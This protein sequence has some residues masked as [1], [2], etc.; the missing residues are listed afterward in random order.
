MLGI[1][2]YAPSRTVVVPRG[3][4]F[5]QAVVLENFR[6]LYG[7]PGRPENPTRALVYCDDAGL[8]V[9]FE[10]SGNVEG[11]SV[12]LHVFGDG[13]RQYA[14]EREDGEETGGGWAAEFRVEWEE[15]GGKGEILRANFARVS[16]AETSSW[17]PVFSRF[18]NEREMGILSLGREAEPER[19]AVPNLLPAPPREPGAREGDEIALGRGLLRL[20]RVE[21]NEIVRGRFPFRSESYHTPEVHRFRERYGLDEVVAGASSELKALQALQAWVISRITFG[22]PHHGRMDAFAIL[23]DAAQ[24]HTFFCTHYGWVFHAAA[25][26]LGWVARKNTCIGHAGAE[27]WVN[28]HDKWVAFEPTRGHIF[29]KDGVPQSAVQVHNEWVRDGGVSMQRQKGPDGEVV[30]VTLE[31]NEQGMIRDAQERFLWFACPTRNDFFGRP[32]HLGAYRWVWY[33][34]EHNANVRELAVREGAK[35]TD[36]R[37]GSRECV[38][39]ATADPRDIEWSANRVEAHLHQVAGGLRVRLYHCMPNLSHFEADSG[40]GWAKADYEFDWPLKPGANTLRVRAVNLFGRAGKE[41]V[42]E[43]EF[44]AKAH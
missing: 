15:L 8:C 27:V 7:E 20:T 32:E 23:D 1:D 6:L 38:M 42:L 9:R 22:E 16:G 14:V 10:C 34:D 24:G 13:H 36:F 28:E 11:D 37:S 3:E 43:G 19:E 26:A 18:A 2:E 25:V 21:G 41:T 12:E 4:G 35:P 17:S 39:L 44:V 5:A 29:L 40:S 30:P 33:K 31:R